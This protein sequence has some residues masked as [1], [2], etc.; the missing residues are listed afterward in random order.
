MV[1]MAAGRSLEETRMLIRYYF[2]ETVR[3]KLARSRLETN[4]VV[5]ASIF[6]LMSFSS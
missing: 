4:F 3:H 6:L 5:I 2:L 1:A